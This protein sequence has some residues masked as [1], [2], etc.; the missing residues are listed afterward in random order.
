MDPE[1][2]G[3]RGGKMIETQRSNNSKDILI[4]F[5]RTRR[6]EERPRSLPVWD[7][8]ISYQSSR[9]SFERLATA[10]TSQQRGG[11]RFKTQ[12]SNDSKDILIDFKRT[13]KREERP[14]SLPVWDST[15]SHQSSRNSSERLETDGARGGERFETH[16]SNDSKDIMTDFKRLVKEDRPRSLPVWDSIMSHHS[17][18]SLERLETD[19]TSQQ[20]GGE[21]FETHRSNDSKDIVTDFK[22]TRRRED[23]PRSLPIWDSTIS[24][25]SSRD[26]FER[27][28]TAG[29]SQQRV[30]DPCPP[31]R[32]AD[33]AQIFE[34]L[35]EQVVSFARAELQ[36]F[37]DVLDE[38]AP[39]HLQDGDEQKQRSSEAMLKISQYFL[40]AMGQ[41]ALAQQLHD[42]IHYPEVCRIKLKSSLKRRCG[43]VYEG[44]A[45]AG[46]SS[47]LRDVYT[48]LHVT[49]PHSEDSKSIPLP[50]L[51][52]PRSS[53]RTVMT[54]GEAGA[55]KSLLTQKFCLDWAEGRAARDIQ[56]LFP[57]TFRELNVLR[58]ARFSLVTLLHHFFSETKKTRLRSF[59]SLNVVFI[60]DGLD[61]SLIPLDFS[62]S[63][64]ISDVEESA[65][66]G[67]LLVNL[68]RG[69]LLPWARVWLIGRP[70]AAGRIPARCVSMMTEVRGFSEEQ[71]EAYFRV[72]FRSPVQASAVLS[73]IRS[74]PSLY[75]LCRLPLFSWILATVLLHV[76]R[77]GLCSSVI[78]ASHSLAHLLCLTSASSP[79]PHLLCLTSSASPPLPHHLCLTSSASPL[80]HLLWCIPS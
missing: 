5:K 21:R 44:I 10:G 75:G 78:S 61:E 35:E 38:G 37:C 72:R 50:L 12:G 64:A 7:S 4:D 41:E 28:A 62:E 31:Q 56:L 43:R 13:R 39:V 32:R 11:E 17:R 60:L 33:K 58:D 45:K 42:Q 51:F 53:T 34:R 14:R 15:M 77:T 73:H 76:L 24:H 23:R 70:A 25:Q 80:H 8:T 1:P 59:D 63:P 40:R 69:D 26:S 79:L 71:R 18:D 20:R 16:R 54:Q 3:P 47:P 74:S 65:S 36:R 46:R 66:L 52:D 9:D 57:F 49:E 6:R 30:K 55:G 48:D 67:E 29:T 2:R 19:G 22:R 27:L 68:L